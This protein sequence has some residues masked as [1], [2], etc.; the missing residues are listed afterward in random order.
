M[1]IAFISLGCPKNLVDTEMI[2]GTA[3]KLGYEIS[4][5]KNADMIVLNTCAFIKLAEDESIDTIERILEYKKND[6]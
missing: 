4:N 1:K 5:E 3:Q 6:K 2:M